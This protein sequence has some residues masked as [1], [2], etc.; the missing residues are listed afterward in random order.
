MRF[1][2][3]LPPQTRVYGA[4]FIYSFCMGSLFPRLP[5]LQRTLGVGEGTLGLSL[6]GTALGTLIALTFAGPLIERFGHRRVVLTLIPLLSAAYATA[7]LAPS[8]PLL[9]LL[10]IPVGLIIGTI[11]I[12]INLE[13]DRVEHQ[14]GRRIMNRAHGF[15]SFGFFASGLVGAVVAQAGVDF[16]LHL[17]SMVPFIIVGTALLLGRF[18]PAPHRAGTSSDAP[19]LLARP[20]PFILALV[21]VALSAMVLEGA[22]ADWSAIYMRDVFLASP[23]LSG[24]A[25]SLGAFAQAVARMFADRF[26]ERYSPVAVA[27]ALISVLFLGTLLVFF[28]AHAVVALAGFALIGIGASAIF[29]LAMS[30]AAQRTDR[31]STL[32]V[33]ALAQ[34]SFSAFLLGPPLLGF[35][36]EHWEIKWS[37]GVCLPLIVLS[38]IMASSLGRKPIPHKVD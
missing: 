32:N 36:A 34:I 20:T 13:A 18:T 21:C 10:L 3:T 25:V 1:G 11:E 16:R 24:F 7:M 6:I 29:P 27:R 19:P 35:I 12:V 9:F 23:F 5:D 17:W 30:A 33:A 37:F 14:V 15:W 26:V 38:F 28:A 22:S 8:P 2:L 4:F 31:S